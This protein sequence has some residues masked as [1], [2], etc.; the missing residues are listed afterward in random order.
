MKAEMDWEMRP[1][2]ML[3]Q[4]RLVDNLTPPPPMIRLRISFGESKFEISVDSRATF[5]ELKKELE[6]KTELR[7]AEQRVIYR[8]KVRENWEF[9]DRCGVKDRSK[10]AVMEDPSSLE[11]RHIEM[12]RDAKMQSTSRAIAGLSLEV[13]KLANQVSAMEKSISGKQKVP[14]LQITTLIELLMREAVKLDGIPAVGDISFQKHFQAKRIQ[15]CV[16][17][18][19]VLKTSNGK[20][21]HVIVTTDWETFDPP[22]TTQLNFLD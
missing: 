17:T 10:L 21:K 4:K 16:E 3:V 12:L 7:L 22:S 18:L 13:D 6:A 20:L 11:R 8:G 9:L 5:R 1:G 15:K 14:D 2:G 19:D